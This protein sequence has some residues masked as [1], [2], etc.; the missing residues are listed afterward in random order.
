VCCRARSGREIRASPEGFV[1]LECDYRRVAVTVLI[2][3]DY[4]SFRT[5]ARELLESVG[6]EVVGEAADG[7]SAI[8]AARELRPDMILLDIVLPDIDGIEVARRLAREPN[9]PAVVL[10]STRD[11]SDFGRRLRD[12]PALG[13]IPKAELSGP[14]LALLVAP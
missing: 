10:T 2:V 14:A 8:A 13:F 11:G 12:A 3:D 4:A 9:A 7:V 5:R 1:L 6:Y